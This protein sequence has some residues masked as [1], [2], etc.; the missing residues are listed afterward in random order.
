KPPLPPAGAFTPTGASIAGEAIPVPVPQP[1]PEIQV[2]TASERAE[3]ERPALKIFPER[4]GC[5]PA[6]VEHI[7]APLR[8]AAALRGRIPYSGVF[9]DSGV[10]NP[11]VG[12]RS[13]RVQ[14]DRA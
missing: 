13:A 12:N 14:R 10:A 5:I 6:S 8:G 7:G 2:T 1:V 9:V 11:V 3:P 4:V